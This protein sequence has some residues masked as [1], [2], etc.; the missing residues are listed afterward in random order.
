[1]DRLEAMTILVAVVETGSFTAAGRRLGVPLPTVSRKLAELEAHLGG[2]RLLTRSTRRLSLTASGADYVAACRRILAEIDDADR[3]AA[4]EYVA[5]RGELVLAAPIVFGR[6]HMVPIVSEFLAAYP[7][8]SVRLLLSDRNAQLL[9]DHI[10]LALRIGVLPDSATIA[11]RVG[12]V[13]HVVCASPA[14]LAAQGRPKVPADL[15]RHA[16]VTFDVAGTATSWS[17]VGPPGLRSVAIRS[18]L[19]VNTAEAA[20]DAAA[21][22]V[23]LTRVLSYQAA[24]AVEDGRL[25]IVLEAFES[26]PLPVSLI[27]L[28]RQV[29]PLKTRSFIDF[30]VRRLKARL[31]SPRKS[32][33]EAESG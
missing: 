11:L 10:D 30:A 20:L 32:G 13:T 33:R 2:T 15:A 7:D 5:P 24:G 31:R 23:G 4:G 19:S 21:Q 12:S 14:Y 1:M 16:C 6:L 29:L 8:I 18:R 22:G 28:P 9:D 17:F 26:E 27:H 25:E 3:K